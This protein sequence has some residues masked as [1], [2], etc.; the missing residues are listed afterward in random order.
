MH[1]CLLS[2][3]FLTL[4][5]AGPSTTTAPATTITATQ[6]ALSGLLA[7]A[8]EQMDAG[9]LLA[10]R[11]TLNDAVAAGSLAPVDQVM[12]KQLLGQISEKMIFSPLRFN[13]DPFAGKY[14]VQKGDILAKIAASNNITTTFLA[15]INRISD[16]RKVRL[17]ATLKTIKGPF[18][19]IVTKHAFTMDIFLG[20]P[21]KPGALLV[22]SLPV[23]LGRDDSTPTGVWMCEPHQ[24]LKNPTYF[25]PRGDGVIEAGDPKNPLGG[26]WIGLTGLD[27]HASGKKSYGVHGT[28]DA[29]SIGTQSS[30]GCIRLRR[31]D[32]AL[33]F[34]LL[35]DGKSTVTVR[36]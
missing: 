13:E 8:K 25:S 3:L 16:P 22:L 24:K 10:A 33:V 7:G 21:N 29:E 15:R 34:D 28:I 6:P 20:E 18:H 12:A 23:G 26:Y 19:A 14:T 17:G 30:L 5:A 36:D 27:G 31:E 4:V 35:V 32:I 9:D 11:T 2:I 1:C